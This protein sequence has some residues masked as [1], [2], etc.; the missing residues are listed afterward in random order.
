MNPE[1]RYLH[2][3]VQDQVAVITLN[4]PEQSNA[5]VSEMR[6]E[7]LDAFLV[8]DASDEVRAIVL[9]GAGDAFC[10][11][12]DLHAM[13]N[14]IESGD[15]WVDTE[16]RIMP[17]RNKVVLAMHRAS[18]PLVA[19]INGAVAGGGMGMALACDIRVASSDAKFSMAFSKLGLHPEWGLS[20][21][22]PRIVGEARAKEL[23]WLA[24]KLSAA[25]ALKLGIVSQVVD[26]D[27]LLPATMDLARSLAAGPPVATRLS[28]KSL[29]R[30][31]GLS[32]EETLDMETYAQNICMASE[33]FREGVTAV[34]E[35]RPPKFIGR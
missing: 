12:G 28:R 32:L 16:H 11:G 13:K 34:V 18:K 20:Y 3:A 35:K 27:D 4:R 1:Y 30:S 29:S 7:L 15:S 25:E 26:A 22:L 21:F 31:L 6:E 2:Y 10:A 19:G 24:P 9:T 8:S 17:V 33:D 23:I 5:I 14:A